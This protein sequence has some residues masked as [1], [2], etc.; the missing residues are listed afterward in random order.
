MKF[1]MGT[2]IAGVIAFIAWSDNPFSEAPV[3]EAPVAE[4]LPVAAPP[5]PKV[6]LPRLEVGTRGVIVL[7]LADLKDQFWEIIPVLGSP[8]REW[9]VG[10]DEYNFPWAE[11]GDRLI[12]LADRGDDSDPARMVLVKMETGRFAGRSYK[13]QRK[14]I[15]ARK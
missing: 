5:P 3:P 11:V 8:N 10:D 1:R 4:P 6:Y 15:E 7:H 12:V 2:A 14:S 9:Q 13:I